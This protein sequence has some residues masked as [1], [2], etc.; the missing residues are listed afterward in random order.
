MA[1]KYYAGSNKIVFNTGNISIMLDLK[2]KTK[3]V[4]D[5]IK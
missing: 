1:K 3:R 2:L 4:T 5:I